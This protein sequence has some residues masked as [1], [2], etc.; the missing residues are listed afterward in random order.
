MKRG[1]EVKVDFT[2]KHH[3]YPAER[4]QT[5]AYFFKKA[6]YRSS[7]AGT[8][9]Y[10][11]RPQ[12]SKNKQTSNFQHPIPRDICYTAGNP[13]AVYQLGCPNSVLVPISLLQVERDTV[14]KQWL[15][16]Y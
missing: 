11:F 12:N 13:L 15:D 3:H 1:G 2:I 4:K 6:F 9:N 14:R 8:S 7:A 10:G 5:I 16:L